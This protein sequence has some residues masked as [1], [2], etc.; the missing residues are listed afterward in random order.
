[1]Y[2]IRQPAVEREKLRLH[3]A[4]QVSG[5]LRQA[6]AACAD[7]GYPLSLPLYRAA[8]TLWTGLHGLVSVQHSLAM[9]E[10]TP[11][12]LALADGLVDLVV[13]TEKRSGPAYPPQTQVDRLIAAS[14]ND[15]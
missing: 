15:Q 5:R 1:M 14:I 10:L 13:S 7:D 4:R 2:E 8:H 6:L 11:E 9:S 12:L 3:P